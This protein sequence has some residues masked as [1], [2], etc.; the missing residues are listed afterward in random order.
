MKKYKLNI[1]LAAKTKVHLKYIINKK[2]S[3]LRTLISKTDYI[4][5]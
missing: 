4:I 5:F 1:T 2:M 3:F